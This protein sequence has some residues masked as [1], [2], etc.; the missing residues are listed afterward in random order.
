MNPLAAILLYQ[1]MEEERTELRELGLTD[2]EIDG[3]FEYFIDSYV[4][5]G[6]NQPALLKGSNNANGT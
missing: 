4:P 3:Y 1:E 6:N 5:M 2:E